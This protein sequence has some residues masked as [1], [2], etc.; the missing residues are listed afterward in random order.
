VA[1]RTAQIGRLFVMDM[2]EQDGL[3][4]RGP[5]EDWKK[6]EEDLFRLNLKPVKGDDTQQKNQ[7]DSGKDDGPFLHNFI[8]YLMRS[9]PVKKKSCDNPVIISC[10]RGWFHSSAPSLIWTCGSAMLRK[11]EARM[12]SK[13]LLGLVLGGGAG[14]G[15]SY[16]TRNIGSS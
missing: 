10:D 2:V 14:F 12:I 3:V 13:I 7:D 11:L 8:C 16:L 9:K 6:R 1:K 4:H 15:L 5:C